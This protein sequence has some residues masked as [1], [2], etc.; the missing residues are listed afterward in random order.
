MAKSTV[1]ISFKVDDGGK[2]LKTLTVDAN[3]LKKAM[4]AT[5]KEAEGLKKSFINF[6]AFATGV[7]AVQDTIRSLQSSVKDL[8]DAYSAQIEAETQLASSMRN[9]MSATDAEIESIKRL[10]SAQQELGVIGDEVQL[11]G[12][13]KLATFLTQ[14]ESLEQLIPVM[15]DM[16]AQQRGYSA[17]AE[18]A[19]NV[20]TM[21]G[22]V[23]NGQVGA[24]T[25]YG[26]KLDEAQTQIIKF[27]SEE[28]RVAVLADVVSSAVG[29]TNEALAQ[30]PYGKVK[31]LANTL[32]DV[33]E[34]LGAVAVKIQPVLDIGA[35]AAISA[36][37]V[38]SLVKGIRTLDAS[39]KGASIAAKTLKWS[40]R[41]LVAAT[42]I[43]LA[44]AALS[45]ILEMFAGKEEDA[46][47]QTESLKQ[48]MRRFASEVRDVSEKVGRYSDAEISRLD[49]LYKAATDEAKSRAERIKA[50]KEL[51]GIYPEYF[52]NMSAEDVALGKAK[53]GYDDL[54]AAIMKNARVKAAADKIVENEA[55]TYEYKR[56][57]D[58]ALKQ[59]ENLLAQK[60]KL[61]EKANA[62]IA[63]ASPNMSGPQKQ[64]MVNSVLNGST[65]KDTDKNKGLNSIAPEAAALNAELSETASLYEENSRLANELASANEEIAKSYGV[66]L[67]DLKSAESGLSSFMV[68][69]PA[70]DAQAQKTRL[71]Q[72]NDEIAKLRDAYVTAD[73]EEQQAIMAKVSA[74]DDEKAKIEEIQKTFDERGGYDFTVNMSNAQF[75]IEEGGLDGLADRLNTMKDLSDAIDIMRQK[76][77][78]ASE[79]EIGEYQKVITAL[80]AKLNAYQSLA[81]SPKTPFNGGAATL[82]DIT[83]NI[84]ILND[85]LQTASE[86]EAALINKEISMWEKKADAIRNAGKAGQD[87]FSLIR[88]GWGGVKGIGNGIEGLTNA[89]KGNG[90]AWSTIVGVIDSALQIYDSIATVMSLVKTITDLTTA[91]KV[92]ETGATIAGTVADSAGAVSASVSGSIMVV[93]AKQ[94]ANAYLELA[95]AKTVAA[96]ADIPWVGIAIAGGMIAAMATLMATVPAFANGGIVSGPTVGLI[97]EYAG[98]SNN[99]EVIAPLD[100][101]RTL[102]Y[103]S[104]SK[105]EKLITR[106]SGQDIEIVLAKRARFKNRM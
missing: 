2:G 19:V 46:E 73:A 3:A 59:Y 95:A 74:L 51:Q 63:K 37:G 39:M 79:E 20:A 80:E 81:Q 102:L 67:E 94:A 66:T 24:L 5:V 58:E 91:S 83:N 98:A 43:G 87:S 4:S 61:A 93:A 68:E 49:R 104:D 103:S 47:D 36:A 33:K 106:I 12:A 34:Q 71:Q 21:F 1:S 16:V 56:K 100:K 48:E 17:T 75:E 22:K 99:P 29:G 26:Y 45:S 96:H 78:E 23:L 41:G 7:S 9:T 31:Q 38:S 30:T 8:T 72:I 85:R 77:R 10:C 86:E 6:A 27:G 57:S 53:K 62:E 55:K 89:L 54:T 44:V 40:I 18:S 52:A 105:D 70:T 90:D 60:R 64:L 69:A 76:Q 14:K 13:Q 50:A 82:K 88:E 11:A 15:N 42:G 84:D 101:L 65:F 35:S 25:R 32:G 97:G 28:E 92:A